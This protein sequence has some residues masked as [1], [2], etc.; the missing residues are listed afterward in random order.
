MYRIKIKGR[1]VRVV[2]LH[3]IQ[4][5]VVVRRERDGPRPRRV[6]VGELHFIFGAD[7]VADDLRVIGVSSAPY[8][9]AA[10]REDGSLSGLL[11]S[12]RPRGPNGLK[13]GKKTTPRLL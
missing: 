5:G 10:T 9:V 7:L 3:V 13:I 12:R 4:R 11:A 8:A 1:Q 6:Q 2:G